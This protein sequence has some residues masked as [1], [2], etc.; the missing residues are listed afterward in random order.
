MRYFTCKGEGQT[1]HRQ[2]DEN[3]QRSR[4]HHIL[5]RKTEMKN[6]LCNHNAT[7]FYLQI[8]IFVLLS[9]VDNGQTRLVVH[10][11]KRNG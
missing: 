11:E 2:G 4:R 3:L 10:L 7:T 5:T 1:S 9:I 6:Y 8:C